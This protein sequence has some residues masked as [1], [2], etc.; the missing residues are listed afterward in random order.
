MGLIA[1]VLYHSF[2]GM[3]I[4]LVDFWPKGAK[5]QQPMFY[6]VLALTLIGVVAMGYFVMLPVFQGC[7]AHQCG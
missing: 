4:T 1:A 7:P 2:N 6:G 3:R 5:Y